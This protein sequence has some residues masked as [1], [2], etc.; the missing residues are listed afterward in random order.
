MQSPPFPRYLVPPRSKYSPQKNHYVNKLWP[1]RTSLSP[2]EK[3][4]VSPP[5]VL[6]EKIYLPPLQVKL[7]LMK[8]FVKGTDKTVRGFEIC[9]E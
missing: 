1:K 6:L 9:E 8:Y 5:L 4:V 2:G 7:G 3:N